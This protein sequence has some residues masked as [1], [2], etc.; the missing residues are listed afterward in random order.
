MVT[1]ALKSRV[2]G[3]KVIAALAVA[4]ERVTVALV[5]GA[6]V[7]QTVIDGLLYPL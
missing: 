2:V 4:S 7:T 5:K 3:E 6:L 1:S